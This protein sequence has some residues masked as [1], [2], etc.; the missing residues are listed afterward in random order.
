M[1]DLQLHPSVEELTAFNLGQLAPQDAAKVESHIG[2]CEP[3]CETLLGLSTDDTFVALLKDTKES[4]DD[5]T[6]D[7]RDDAL[8]SDSR[9][10]S[11]AQSPLADHPRYR[12]LEL[13]GTQCVFEF[14]QRHVRL[15]GN[16]SLD[17]LLVNGPSGRSF[18]RGQ[19]GRLTQLAAFLFDASHPRLAHIEPQ[20]HSP[21][22]STGIAGAQHITTHFL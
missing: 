16:Q 15:L 13:I 18:A 20:R 21:G 22:A 5:L 14:L 1:P 4:D 10:E 6:I 7:R 3:C 9:P 8:K 19:G 17:V 2:E 11:A 12:V